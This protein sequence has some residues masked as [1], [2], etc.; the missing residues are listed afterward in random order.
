M[1]LW[2]RGKPSQEKMYQPVRSCSGCPETSTCS[3]NYAGLCSIN[4]Y[5]SGFVTSSR[6]TKGL[7]NK[8]NTRTSNI[9]TNN[10]I[11]TTNRISSMNNIN[12]ISYSQREKKRIIPNIST[13]RE[14]RLAE[15]RTLPRL[16]A[17][18]QRR[19]TRQRTQSSPCRNIWCQIARFFQ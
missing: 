3:T 16:E 5:N 8:N 15:A 1:Q 7:I 4:A 6:I 12:I 18:S 13:R 10:R 2:L 9:I 14:P 11:T 17:D 19:V